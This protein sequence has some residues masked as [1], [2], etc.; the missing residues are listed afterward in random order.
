MAES[1]PV[2]TSKEF[3]ITVSSVLGAIIV[4]AGVIEVFGLTFFYDTLAKPALIP[5]LVLPPLA[6]LAYVIYLVI[7]RSGRRG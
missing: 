2:T 3:H 6:A 5:L 7:G 1:K 4:V